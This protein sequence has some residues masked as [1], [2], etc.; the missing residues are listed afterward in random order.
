MRIKSWTASA[1]IGALLTIAAASPA[2]ASNLLTN[3]SFEDPIIAANSSEQYRA[4]FQGQVI[5]T[6]NGSPWVYTYH[7][8]GP[9][10]APATYVIAD[11][12]PDFGGKTTPFGNQ[13]YFTG[14]SS[15]STLTTQGLP[16]IAPGH[17][18]LSFWQ[19]S[20]VGVAGAVRADVRLGY[21]NAH[22]S[23][24]GGGQ[25]FTVGAGS[26][27]VRQSLQFDISSPTFGFIAL[28]SIQGG[29]PGL[30]DNFELNLVPPGGGV[31]EPA[32]WALM[33]LGFAGMG[34]VIRRR[35]GL[36]A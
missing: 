12:A 26:D 32:T 16:S 15:V 20:F 34:A 31:P 8:G 19:S 23:L 35:R 22:T 30:V 33:I 25:L 4:F 3:G 14:Y 18:E 11:N 13:F 1:A 10:V 27:W 2:A 17:Y 36:A 29:G 24:F 28:E 21:A 7:T 5:G 9:F 6:N